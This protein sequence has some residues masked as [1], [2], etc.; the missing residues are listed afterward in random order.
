MIIEEITAQEMLEMARDGRPNVKYVTNDKEDFIGAW[1]EDL[2]RY[3]AVAGKLITGKWM[4][5]PHEL[6]VNGKPVP[7]NW[8]D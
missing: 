2:G 8:I 5:L 3:V 7:V 6:L 4:N 1:V